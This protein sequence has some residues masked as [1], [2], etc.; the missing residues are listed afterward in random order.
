[1]TVSSM[2]L[3]LV[4]TRAF[5]GNGN[6]AVCGLGIAPGP[7]GQTGL[8]SGNQL[9]NGYIKFT[10]CSLELVMIFFFE[11][12]HLWLQAQEVSDLPIT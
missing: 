3:E 7:V 8:A 6:R 1:M 5:D 4:N 12:D 10:S 9:V 2:I 11:T